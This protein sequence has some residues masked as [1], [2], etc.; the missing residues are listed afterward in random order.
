MHFYILCPGYQ[1]STWAGFQEHTSRI[2]LPD[3]MSRVH[4]LKYFQFMCQET[5]NY[6]GSLQISMYLTP[7]NRTDIFVHGLYLLTTP[8]V[9]Y[10]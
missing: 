9:M 7:G 3:N 5:E 4:V 2:C 6:C 8:D 10:D 1:A